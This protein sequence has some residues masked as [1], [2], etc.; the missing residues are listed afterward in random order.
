MRETS[1]PPPDRIRCL[2]GYK[3]VGFEVDKHMAIEIKNNV[4]AVG[5]KR[6]KDAPDQVLAV[7]E[8]GN[9]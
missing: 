7:C 8:S 1:S 4:D 9:K 3:V 5:R 6:K 2:L